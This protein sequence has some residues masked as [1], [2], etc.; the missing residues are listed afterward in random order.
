MSADTKKKSTSLIQ[1]YATLLGD[2]VLRHRVRTAE[3][4]ARLEAELTDRVK[5]DFISNMS[6]ELRTPLNTVMGFSKLLSEH[7]K[8]KIGD[9]DIVQYASLIHDAASHLLSIINDILDISKM[10]SGNFALE[11]EE[12]D[13]RLL[14]S[15]CLEDI[16]A[17]AAGAG[18]TL[19]TRVSVGLPA[20]RGDEAKLA[21]AFSNLL[22]NAV[23][24]TP[25]GGD[26]T[27]E[28]HEHSD[29][30]VLISIRDTGI[31][32]T[33]EEIRVALEPFGQVDGGRARWREGTGLG[34]PI[35]KALV[36]LHHGQFM[37]SSEKGRGTEVNLLLPPAYQVTV[38]EA[39]DAVFGRGMHV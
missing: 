13:L 1:E 39:R 36:E 32:M 17:P 37:I 23:K 9:A 38:A 28:A 11:A 8:Q 24:F 30:G 15:E 7:E 34:L 12:V 31:G 19:H 35:A 4:R 10:R 25:Q 21:Q 18:L 2:A 22:S 26:I 5:S 6:H 20:I 14:L 3:H 33:P 29:G 16:S 27:F